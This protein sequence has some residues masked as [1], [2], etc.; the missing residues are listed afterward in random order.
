MA[1]EETTKRRSD[2]DLP[3]LHV[4]VPER[5]GNTAFWLGLVG[6]VAVGAV[7]A[8]VAVLVGAGVAIVR[9]RAGRR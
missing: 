4:R 2:Y 3:L 8:P 9:H 7:E 6:T 1:P 5:V